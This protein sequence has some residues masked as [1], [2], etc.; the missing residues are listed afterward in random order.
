M[1]NIV[2]LFKNKLY[3]IDLSTTERVGQYLYSCPLLGSITPL[4]VGVFLP[5]D[6]AL[7]K[8]KPT[9]LQRSYHDKAGGAGLPA[10]RLRSS[11]SGMN[12]SL[13]LGGS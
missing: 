4:G 11:G 1:N 2:R 12:T 5:T 10:G 9:K 13:S 8:C 3:I 7:A 6:Y